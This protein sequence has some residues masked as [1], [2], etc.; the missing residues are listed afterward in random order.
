MT[1]KTQWWTS[2]APRF[3]P[4]WI[5]VN[6]AMYKKELA[7]DGDIVIHMKVGFHKALNGLD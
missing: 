5:D 2:A 6:D 7:P 4:R 3:K 1:P